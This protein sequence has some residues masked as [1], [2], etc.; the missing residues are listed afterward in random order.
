L[1]ALLGAHLILHF[2]RIRVKNLTS[3][4]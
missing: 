4:I 2:S 1:L 3:Y